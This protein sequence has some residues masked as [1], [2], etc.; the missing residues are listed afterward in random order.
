MAELLSC[1]FCGG[2]PFV[3]ISGSKSCGFF[4][5]IICEKCGC[6]TDRLKEGIAKDAW[7]TRTPKERGGE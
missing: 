4:E 1:P 2:K 7:N 3:Y 5:E 6:R